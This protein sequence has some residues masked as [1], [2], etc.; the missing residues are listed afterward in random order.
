MTGRDVTPAPGRATQA[1]GE[2]DEGAEAPISSNLL[3]MTFLLVALVTVTSLLGLLTPW[4]YATESEIWRLQARGQDLGNL[5]AVAVLL[6]A[7]ACA[8]RAS[9]AAAQLWLGALLYLAYAF[10]LY[11]FDVHFGRLFLPYV[12]CLGMSAYGLMFGLAGIRNRRAP[13]PEP[14]KSVRWVVAAIAILFA[15]L[16][17]SSIVPATITG[18][19]PSQLVEAGLASNPVHVL[20]LALV[21]PGMVI[22]SYLAGRGVPVARFLL[23]AWL[24]FGVLMGASIVIAHLLVAS[25]PISL[26]AMGAVTATCAVTGA[27]SLRRS[28]RA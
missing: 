28:S 22:T 15:V 7:V 12:A 4:P 24:V 5:L 8:R 1:G 6:A 19:T 3:M 18:Q 17:L 9:L 25:S 10:V 2:R 26:I 11:S 13:L 27:A 21:L 14:T 20:D 23:P 16:W